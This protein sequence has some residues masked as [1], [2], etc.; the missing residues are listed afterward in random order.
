MSSEIESMLPL[1]S[2]IDSLSSFSRRGHAV[3]A[4]RLKPL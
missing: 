3:G 1:Q 2:I 4:H